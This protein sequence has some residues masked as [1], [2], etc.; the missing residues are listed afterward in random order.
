MEGVGMEANIVFLPGDG[1]GPEISIVA[2]KIL[3]AVETKYGHK[4][5]IE[6]AFIGGV[7]IDK[8]GQPLPS[9]TLSL[10]KE[11]D[12][13]FLAAV[14]GP[15]WDHP[16]DNIRPEQGLLA[17]RK[18]LETF[19]NIRPVRIYPTLKHRSPLKEERLG[20]VDLLIIRELTGGIYFGEKKHSSD[21]AFDGCPYHAHEIK[22]IAEISCQFAMARRKHLTL[23]DKANVLATSRLW[24]QVVTEVVKT[25][26]PQL[27]LHYQLVDSAAMLII[28]QPSFF[29]V[30][31]TENMFG[32][33]LSD[34]ASVLSGSIGLLASA[35]LSSSHGGIYEPIHGS[36][37][38]IAGKNCA[39]PYGA[40]SSISLL[41]RYGLK[42]IDEADTL[43]Q[44]IEQ[45]I[46]D[47][48]LTQDLVSK[49]K[50]FSTTEVGEQ[51]IKRLDMKAC[52]SE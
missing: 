2:K 17:L 50:A 48:V 11:A 41:L 46:Q 3:K 34:E 9:N 10:C 32:D 47:S 24:R 52:T 37:P 36:A 4:F 19:A 29:D 18:E 23:V 39:N 8:T 27:T 35:S 26:F 31:L 33:I 38:D 12:A 43:D 1:I 42:L 44:A 6:E 51:I 5:S 40:I 13:V 25:Q 45:G 30:M 22:R 16:K 49:G 7:A 15:K 21:Y 28:Q 20:K 14:G